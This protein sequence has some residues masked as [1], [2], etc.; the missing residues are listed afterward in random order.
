[1]SADERAIPHHLL[2]AAQLHASPD[3]ALLLLDELH[4]EVR[5]VLLGT[6]EL[7]DVRGGLGL[8]LP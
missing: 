1:M 8:L 3:G 2:D 6:I 5:E 7:G 4:L